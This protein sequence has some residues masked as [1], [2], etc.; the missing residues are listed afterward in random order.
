M[1]EHFFACVHVNVFPCLLRSEENV[2][3]F[4]LANNFLFCVDAPFWRYLAQYGISNA[5]PPNPHPRNPQFGSEF[6]KSKK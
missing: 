3:S 5:H 2:R 4:L 1:I 6:P